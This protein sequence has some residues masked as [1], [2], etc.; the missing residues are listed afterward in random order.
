MAK[1]GNRLSKLKRNQY[2]LYLMVFGLSAIIIWVVGSLFSSQQE[3]KV[4]AELI[5]LARP[6]NPN[7]DQE[8]IEKI[9]QKTT[10]GPSE[11]VQFPIY[12]I[13]T[14]RDGRA[15]EVVT[16]DVADD[17][18]ENRPTPLPFQN[19]QALPAFIPGATPTPT[20]TLP[21]NPLLPTTPQT[22]SDTETSI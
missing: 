21:N 10:Y 17:S 12:K 20:P 9:E 16:I 7:I 1:G 5:R 18:L 14:S 3:T 6:L 4:D 22:T 13:I 11:L 15:T 2:I 8:V 19:P